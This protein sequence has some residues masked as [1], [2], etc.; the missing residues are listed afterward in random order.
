M[1][2]A[3]G[4][5]PAGCQTGNAAPI[6]GG[7]VC[8]AIRLIRGVR[9]GAGVLQAAPSA[10]LRR[11]GAEAS[12]VSPPQEPGCRLKTAQGDSKIGGA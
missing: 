10:A 12:S 11:G 5:L 8:T 4:R 9:Y 6:A 3:A 7:V 1:G 2:A